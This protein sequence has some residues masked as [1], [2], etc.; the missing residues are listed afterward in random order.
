MLRLR[1]NMLR[2]TA[3]KSQVHAFNTAVNERLDDANFVLEH[4]KARFTLLDKYQNNFD[5][6]QWE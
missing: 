5:L 6:P 3:I 1:S 4:N 2:M